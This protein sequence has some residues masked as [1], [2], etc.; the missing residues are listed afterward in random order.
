MSYERERTVK[1]GVSCEVDI[2]FSDGVY[3]NYEGKLTLD[4]LK[5]VGSL[6]NKRRNESFTIVD[7]VLHADLSYYND[8]IVYPELYEND[9]EDINIMMGHTQTVPILKLDSDGNVS[10]IDIEEVDLDCDEVSDIILLN[11]D[12]D[13][14]DEDEVD[15]WENLVDESCERI[16][17][18]RGEIWNEFWEIVDELYYNEDDEDDDEDE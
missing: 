1:Y 8:L 16:G 12:I 5:E 4:Q 7:N 6:L 10:S 14:Y 2:N 17:S 13:V 3:A 15:K 11:A 18:L 9:F